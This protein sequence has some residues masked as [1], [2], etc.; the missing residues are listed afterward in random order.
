MHPQDH[1]SFGSN[2]PGKNLF[3]N[4]IVEETGRE[5]VMWPDHCVQNTF[6]AEFHK[7]IVIKDSDIQILKG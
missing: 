2:H 6:G 4:I 3:E 1:V 7:D 5:Q